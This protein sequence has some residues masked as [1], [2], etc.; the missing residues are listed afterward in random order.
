MARP[1]GLTAASFLGTGW[2][3]PMPSDRTAGSRL[4][5]G[6]QMVAESIWLVL[7]TA[8]GERVMHPRFGCGVHHCS[9][10]AT[11]RATHAAVAHH[12]RE[13]LLDREPRID[14][15]DVRV[16]DRGRSRQRAAGRRSTT[17]SA[18]TTP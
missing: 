2:R 4:A 7:S 5:G 13:A 14:V 1:A 9:S 10:P 3:F 8:P 12:V 15:L 16:E 17:G 18:T 11:R 6:E